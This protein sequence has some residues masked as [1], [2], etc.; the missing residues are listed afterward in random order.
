M[1]TAGVLLCTAAHA[2]MLFTIPPGVSGG[3][4]NVRTGPGI[5]Y[6]LIGAIPSG[7]TVRASR[8]VPRDD[9]VR[10]A[11]WCLVTWKGMEGWVSQAGLM[12]VPVAPPPVAPP[13]G[14]KAPDSLRVEKGGRVKMVEMP[15]AEK[16]AGRPSKGRKKK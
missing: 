13:Y 16:P 2:D 11:D 5:N 14:P 1:A 12:P 4:M 15:E 10:G 3:H 6:G 7:Q 9:G 8:C